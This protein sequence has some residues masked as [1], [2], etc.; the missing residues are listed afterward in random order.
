MPVS[1]SEFFIIVLATAAKT[2][3]M[4]DVSVACVILQWMVRFRVLSRRQG[5]LLWVYTKLCPVGL[6]KPPQD[7]LGCLVRIR[8]TRVLLEVSFQ[9]YLGTGWFAE[10]RKQRQLL[11]L[12]SLCRKMSILFKNKIIDV[13]RNHREL[14]TE[15]KRT[16]DSAIRF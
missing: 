6:H 9:R 12:R 11:T 14:I 15:S 8:P 10:K 4:F 2:S 5:H 1:S 3:R 13:L 7:V 16:R